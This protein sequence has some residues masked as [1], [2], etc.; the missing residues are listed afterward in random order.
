MVSPFHCVFLAV[1]ALS[2]PA[3]EEKEP[4]MRIAARSDT[5]RVRMTNEDAVLIDDDRG[6]VALA[7]GMGGHARGAEASRLAVETA[8]AFLGARLHR[9]ATGDAMTD[10]LVAAVHA[11][12]AA[13]Q[14]ENTGLTGRAAMG[15]TLIVCA[16][17]GPEIRYAHVGDSRLYVVPADG[18]ATRQATRDQTLAQ[19]L[20]DEGAPYASVTR[21]HHTVVEQTVGLHRAIVPETGVVTLAPGDTALLCT[22]GLSDMVDEDALAAIV[23]AHAGNPDAAAGALVDAANRAGG[24][25]NITAVIID[26]SPAAVPPRHGP[27]A[28]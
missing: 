27:H 2:F 11:A 7:D 6:L 21:W 26:P 3:R 1:P 13:L 16:V 9:L 28:E 25:D 14:R 23:R 8:L 24:I 20:L 12:N 19:R 4:A 5:G 17:A 10:L 15:T 22:D 18:G